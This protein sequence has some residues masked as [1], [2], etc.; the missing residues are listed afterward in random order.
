MT[1]VEETTISVKSRLSYLFSATRRERRSALIGYVM[2]G[3]PS[4]KKTLQAMGDLVDNGVDIIELGFPFT[5]PMA[6][7]PV[8][9]RA[10]LRALE[11]GVSLSDV[12]ELVRRFRKTNSDTPIILMGYANP[13]FTMGYA[14]FARQLRACGG[15]GVILV[16]IPLEESEPIQQPLRDEG[17]AL[18][19]LATP[20][21]NPERLTKIGQGADGFIYFVSVAGVTGDKSAELGDLAPQI[22][23][24]R[25]V[26]GVPVCVGFGIR[27]PED[28]SKAAQI[29]DG[30]VVGSAIVQF[31][32]DLANTPSRHD[33]LRQLRA[34]YVG[35]LAKSLKLV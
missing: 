20:T 15:D 6:D 21:S 11:N 29:A 22:E 26:S 30:V 9:Q 31:S 2:A 8:I 28:V 19:R 4:L 35:E 3:D 33:E 24:L 16:D 13:A 12:F 1:S 25:F 5:D 7:G 23:H 10:S 14:E 18:I 32:E 34:E 17:L 27:T